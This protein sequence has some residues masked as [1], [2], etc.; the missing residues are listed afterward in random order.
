MSTMSSLQQLLRKNLFINLRKFSSEN[1]NSGGH[2][3]GAG[4]VFGKKEKAQEEQYFRQKE[5]EELTQFKK[6]LEE[7]DKSKSDKSSKNN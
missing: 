2:I 3:R 7:K 1:G 5:K 4:G 6:K